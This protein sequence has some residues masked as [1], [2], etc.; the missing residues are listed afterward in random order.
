MKQDF[1][2]LDGS[3]SSTES[4][5]DQIESLADSFGFD[6]RD[7]AFAR[8]LAEEAV[9]A[10]SS[11]IGVNSGSMWVEM[12]GDDFD[13]HLK[14][15]A[16]LN[17]DNR[18]NLINLSKNKKNTPKKGIIGKLA[19][20]I[21][22]IASDSAIGE[23]PFMF[24]NISDESISLAASLLPSDAAYWS[25]KKEQKKQ[26][27]KNELTDIEQSIIERFADDIIVSIALKDIEIVIKKIRK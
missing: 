7:A 17:S 19:S 14:S 27:E 20:F 2:K 6:S 21:D 12:K 24:Y 9:N 1:M 18:E 11:I 25:M 3:A 5:L 15:N 13:I 16:E 4:A 8:L 10:F 26:E 22:Y 23:N